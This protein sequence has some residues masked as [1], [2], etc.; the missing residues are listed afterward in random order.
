VKER[1]TTT[2]KSMAFYRDI[3]G[4]QIS[5][6]QVFY[7]C[8]LKIYVDACGLV[9]WDGLRVVGS[10]RQPLPSHGVSTVFV[11]LGNTKIEV[12]SLSSWLPGTFISITKGWW[13]GCM[14]WGG[15]TVS[16]D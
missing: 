16:C 15:G 11:N 2:E 8:P 5:D 3:L 4:A 9:A 14:F 1:L 7:P 12:R 13:A 10:A 6:I